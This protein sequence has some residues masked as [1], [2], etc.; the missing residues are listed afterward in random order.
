LLDRQSDRVQIETES[1]I[2]VRPKTV[3]GS[4]VELRKFS[5][6]FPTGTLI[7]DCFLRTES[8]VVGVYLKWHNLRCWISSPEN[9]ARQLFQSQRIRWPG[10]IRE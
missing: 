3:S 8:N 9:Q 5:P 10:F 1:L 2:E 4:A 7:Q 6:V